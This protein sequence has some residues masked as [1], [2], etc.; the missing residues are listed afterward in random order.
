MPAADTHVVDQVGEGH[1]L[2]EKDP[3]EF[4]DPDA[5]H[6]IVSSADDGDYPTGT[7]MV[8]VVVALIVAIFLTSMD[9]VSS[10]NPHY[11]R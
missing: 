9:F 3:P 1:S 4:Q 7:R 5:T 8:F 6:G 2:Q 11:I 10:L